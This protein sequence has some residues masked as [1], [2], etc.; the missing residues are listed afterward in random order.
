MGIY[1]KYLVSQIL[2]NGKK[3]AMPKKDRAEV[4]KGLNSGKI[5]AVC[6]TY[7]LFST[8]IDVS[9]LEVLILAAPI[10]SEIKLKQSLGRIFRKSKIKKNPIV[11][12]FIDY[13]IDLLKNQSYA[14]NRVYKYLEE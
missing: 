5:R 12:D 3:R 1:S 8:G 6:S 7:G 9:T 4:I 2:V 11:V 13:K 14:R 10:R